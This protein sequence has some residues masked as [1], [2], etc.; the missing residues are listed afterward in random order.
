MR[1]TQPYRRRGSASFWLGLLM[2]LLMAAGG[3]VGL[4]LLLGVNL[5]PFAAPREDPF[6]VRIP[7][8]SRPIPAYERVVR[9]HL[10]NPATG[11]LMYQRVPPQS[12]VGMSITGVTGDGSHVEGRVE[13]VRNVNDQVVFV[14][15]DGRE[16]PQ[17]QTLELG[18]A[19]MNVNAIIGRVVKKDKRAGMGFQESSFFPQG[20]PEGIAGATPPGMRAVTL[21]AT[22][23]TGVHAL[24]AGD[25]IDLMASVP[26]GEVGS[27]QS[28]HNSRLPGAALV[29]PASSKGPDS[30]TEP[31]LLA[32]GAVVLKP[33][34]VRNEATTSSSLTQGKRIQNVPKYEVAIAVAPDDVI[35]L[36]SALNKSLAITCIAHSMQPG[37]TTESVSIGA[38]AADEQPAPVTVR[39]IL[40]YEVVSRE[41]F[42]SPATRRARMEPVSQREI[43]RQGIITSLDEALGA[44]ARHDIPAGRFLRK[45]DLLSDSIKPRSARGS[46]V[47]ST[48]AAT[49]EAAYPAFRFSS[50]SARLASL[51]EPAAGPTPTT[52]GDRPAITRFVPPGY[53]A[54]AIPWNRVYGAEHLQIGDELDLLASY[55]LESEDEEEEVEK[56]PDGSTITRKRH[57]I[58][59]RETIRSWDESLGLRGEPWFVASGAI[60]VG[61]VGFPAPAAAL[62][63]LGENANRQATG[64]NAD[65]LSGPPLLI[66]VDDRDVETVAAALATRRVLFTAAFHPSDEKP[67]PEAGTKRIAI[68]AQDIAAYEQISDTV[69]NGNRRRPVSR[70][71]A[72]ADARFEDALTVEQLRG[73]EF[74]VLRRAKR[75]GEFFTSDDFL[76]EGTG[77]GLAAAAGAGETIFAVADREIEGLDAFQANDLVAILVRG[78]VEPPTGVI[79]H[80][81][82]LRRPVSAVVVPSARIVRRSQAGQTILAV[83]DADL[84]RLQAAWAASMT[85]DVGG[86]DSGRSHL[87]AVALPRGISPAAVNQG[88]EQRVA[89]TVPP[90]HAP[91]PNR[92][93]SST[94]WTRQPDRSSESIPAFDPLGEIKLTEAIVGQRREWHAFAGEPGSSTSPRAPEWNFTR[95]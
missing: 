42:V 38:A 3:V 15:S 46:E 53:T 75:R 18:G 51:Q 39:A 13:S 84:T 95:Q 28:R 93:V 62:R 11:G 79:T 10:L 83:P 49:R 54:F 21:D 34:Y 64:G 35:P 41:A 17:N 90:S 78:V 9:E 57:D 22:K 94:D 45:S 61:P 30:A 91:P 92:F 14:L 55:S 32:H 48:D 87:L 20:T 70:A 19:I 81:F 40:A 71:V 82:S 76:P 85:D 58:S 59:T 12:A 50:G 36:Q 60:V 8:N 7:I 16:V 33:V 24:N 27:F 68:V 77:P 1:P 69:W 31:M 74:R 29:A 26:V 2:I 73:F 67:E 80:G 63:A 47:E 66:A 72:S 5:N 44:V 88:G 23:L 52:V 6:M 4:L 65:S 25:Q 37:D 43:D 86:N 56:R 89:D